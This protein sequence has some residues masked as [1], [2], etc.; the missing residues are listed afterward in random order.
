MIGF[1]GEMTWGDEPSGLGYDLIRD[2]YR[3]DVLHF[4]CIR[5]S[6]DP[7]RVMRF[8]SEAMRSHLK[9]AIDAWPQFDVD[10]DVNG[11]ELV[12]WFGDWR[13]RARELL[14]SSSGS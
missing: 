3:L 1:A 9:A 5:G 14:G 11:V 2:G 7:T 6:L 10:A 13:R 8:P 4:F 12:E